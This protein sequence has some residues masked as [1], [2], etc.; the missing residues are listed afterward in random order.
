MILVYLNQAA[1]GKGTASGEGG[2]VNR[3]PAKRSSHSD[4]EPG[5]DEHTGDFLP[6]RTGVLLDEVESNRGLALFPWPRLVFLCLGD[7]LVVV[8]AGGGVVTCI[9]ELVPLEEEEKDVPLVGVKAAAKRNFSIIRSIS[10]TM[11]L[12]FRFYDFFAIFSFFG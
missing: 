11:L 3:A 10:L 6:L 12:F 7:R 4:P 5:D 2:S 8:V 1:G 9:G